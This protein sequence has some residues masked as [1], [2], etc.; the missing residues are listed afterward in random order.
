MLVRMGWY[1]QKAKAAL[2]QPCALLPRH[3]GG[4]T[5]LRVSSGATGVKWRVI[6]PALIPRRPGDRVKTDR[7]DARKLAELLRADLLTVVHPPTSRPGGGARPSAGRAR[8]PWPT[9]CGRATGWRSCALV[10]PSPPV[11]EPDRRD[12]R[13]CCLTTGHSISESPT[14]SATRPREHTP[15]S[16]TTAWNP[17]W[18]ESDDCLVRHQVTEVHRRS[19][20]PR[21]WSVSTLAGASARY[22]QQRVHQIRSLALLIGKDVRVRI[23]RE[24]HARM[25]EAL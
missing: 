6:A 19:A 18:S 4:C 1:P 12:H 8:T 16:G 15:N 24:R 25:P 22:G 2:R 23:E 11:P 17:Q 21:P 7:R 3:A 13:R 20:Q 14:T 10:R 9:A 5:Q